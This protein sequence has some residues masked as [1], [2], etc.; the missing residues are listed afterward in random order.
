MSSFEDYIGKQPTAYGLMDSDPVFIFECNSIVRLVKR[1]LGDDILTVELTN[2]Q[3]YTCLEFSFME[4]GKLV[5]SYQI[6]SQISS[7]LGLTNAFSGSVVSGTLSSSYSVTGLYPQ[8]SF[9]F[10]MRQ[11]D[12][13]AAYSGLGGQYSNDLVYFDLESGKQNYNLYTE[14]KDVSGSLYHTTVPSS[15]LGSKI[16]VF[17]VFHYEPLAAQSYLINGGSNSN[18]IASE[19]NY[20]SYTAVNSSVFRVLPVFE[21]ILRRSMLETAAR[22]RRSHYSYRIQGRE[23]QVFPVPNNLDRYGTKLWLR[24]ARNF[25][26]YSSINPAVE[27]NGYLVPG[28]TSTSVSG[29]GVGGVVGSPSQIPITIIPPALI[30]EVGRQWVRAYCLALCKMVLGRVRG[31][32]RT[33]PIPGSDLEL[34][35]DELINEAKEEMEKLRTDFKEFLGN[36]SYDKIIETEANKAESMNRFLKLQ[37]FPLGKA[38]YIG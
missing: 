29:V 11:A 37:P 31:K 14:L 16:R 33:I 17:D 1:L 23:I 15:S 21:D 18:M 5:G 10:M 28:T 20:D 19:F 8:T 24:V 4:Y 34:N 13:Y 35:H 7:L 25:D 32:F 38:I 3:I 26:N 12:A 9:D 30:N 22:V 6:Q 2:R 36:L 27:A